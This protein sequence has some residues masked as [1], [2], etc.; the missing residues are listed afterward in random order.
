MVEEVASL[1]RQREAWLL[2]R[3]TLESPTEIY[4]RLFGDLQADL[5]FL[6]H[7]ESFSELQRQAWGVLEAEMN[8]YWPKI[9]AGIDERE[10]LNDPKWQIV[11]DAACHFLASFKE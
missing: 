1:E 7:S 5:F 9:A 2:Q 4:E 10:V 3:P 11:R 8:A 6:E